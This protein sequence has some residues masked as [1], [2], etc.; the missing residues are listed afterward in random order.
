M[1]FK[2]GSGSY[3]PRKTIIEDDLD[4]N[5]NY[6]DSAADVTFEDGKI[7]MDLS[8]GNLFRMP[9]LYGFAQTTT[10]NN[11]FLRSGILG[12]KPVEAELTFKNWPEP[13]QMKRVALLQEHVPSFRRER[14]G[15]SN[16]QNRNDV[17]MLS[18]SDSCQ[19]KFEYFNLNHT[20]QYMLSKKTIS[21]GAS[22]GGVYL[23]RHD[24]DSASAQLDLQNLSTTL[25]GAA[26]QVK[27]YPN[28]LD[29]ADEAT[30]N[31]NHERFFWNGDGTAVYLNNKEEDTFV[32]FPLTTK[33]DL[34][35]VDKS[36]IVT[37]DYTAYTSNTTPDL[38]MP[39]FANNGY[40]LFAMDY[41]LSGT[42]SDAYG[43]QSF[44]M[45]TPYDLSTIYEGKWK[46]MSNGIISYPQ[47]VL[48]DPNGDNIYVTMQNGGSYPMY[49]WR[50]SMSTTPFDLNTSSVTST[51]NWPTENGSWGAIQ[52][53]TDNLRFAQFAGPR[54]DSILQLETGG[55][56]YSSDRRFTLTDETRRL[57]RSPNGNIQASAY[58]ADSD[59]NLQEKDQFVK[60][61]QPL[62]SRIKVSSLFTRQD[63]SDGAN[64]YGT[65]E[66]PHP[67]GI[68][69]YEFLVFDSSEGAILTNLR[70]GRDQQDTN[71]Q[72]PGEA[73][74]DQPGIYKFYFPNGVFDFSAVCVGGG[75][76][77]GS[78]TQTIISTNGDAKLGSGGGGGGG[79]QLAYKNDIAV[80][81]HGFVWVTVG[82]GG[83]APYSG[84][85]A[86]AT[87]TNDDGGFSAIEA[88]SETYT[89][90]GN[91]I[92]AWGGY[93]PGPVSQPTGTGDIVADGGW[94]GYQGANAAYDTGNYVL[95]GGAG[96]GGA[97]GFFNNTNHQNG[98]GG[99]FHTSTS[100]FYYPKSGQYA[101]GAENGGGGGTGGYYKGTAVAD[102][103]AGPGAR[104]GGVALFGTK[105]KSTSPT[106][107]TR[108]YGEAGTNGDKN[109]AFFSNGTGGGTAA[110]KLG[111]TTVLQSSD[112]QPIDTYTQFGWGGG[113]N[114]F[115]HD[116]NEG[117]NNS[118][119][120]GG[121]AGG[122]GGVRIIWGNNRVKRQ[123]PSKN[124]GHEKSAI[125]YFNQGKI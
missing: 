71:N 107:Q 6:V 103:S 30:I 117:L 47:S 29:S 56:G 120:S 124:A 44:R 95:Q 8:K 100:S 52:Q 61:W 11:K 79:G 40:Y 80:P 66:Y 121:Q 33:W 3:Y 24:L 115:N 1:A 76:G 37:T 57:Q 77:G 67:D 92:K 39:T 4:I 82:K 96:G 104:G 84:D 70:T 86:V 18:Q 55:T 20:G 75:A 42:G 119:L 62:D 49:C 111:Q 108:V 21:S 27:F 105:Y 45:S 109:V 51:T 73:I 17:G 28:F 54:G 53:R 81:A 110:Y 98:Q 78:G 60:N 94:G 69:Y 5:L 35:T 14:L 38:K 7:V 65:I 26:Q 125:V 123:F 31:S 43:I 19:Y 34:T 41:G 99:I 10:D 46:Q 2:I 93:G 102:R 113:G 50:I 64:T 12:T 32:K 106:G 101:S 87:D 122:N 97:G 13:G 22:G 36:G 112:G 58:M 16:V 90:S 72:M 89:T 118:Q 88:T 48:P 74:F 83:D 114:A 25:A 63:S 91:E 9:D 59:I 116:T 85:S 23:V 15:N 68:N